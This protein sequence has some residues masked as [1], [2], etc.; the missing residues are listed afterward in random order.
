[1]LREDTGQAL[2]AEISRDRYRQLRL[3]IG[4]TVGVTARNVRVFAKQ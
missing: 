1:L 2:E 4:D 3:S